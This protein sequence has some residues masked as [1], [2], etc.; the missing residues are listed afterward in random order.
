MRDDKKIIVLAG[1]GRNL[2]KTWLAC[3]LLEQFG[4]HGVAA[5]KVSNHFHP[6]DAASDFLLNEP[7]CRII[8]ET[9]L[10]HKDSMLMLNAGA[11]P[12]YFIQASDERLPEAYGL[13]TSQITPDT[14]IIIESP[15]LYK[16]LKH[17]SK[18]FLHTHGDAEAILANIN[19]SPEQWIINQPL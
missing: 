4:A 16:L 7:D 15:R 5:I 13:V 11:K 12:V 8:R 17:A 18:V 9:Q 1:A 14:P 6:V 3:R 10:G 2:G 19:L